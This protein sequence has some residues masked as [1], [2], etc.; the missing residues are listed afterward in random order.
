[1]FEID[2]KGA[3]DAINAQEVELTEFGSII[4][5]YQTLLSLDKSLSVHYVR[6]EANKATTVSF[7][8]LSCLHFPL[9]N[10]C[11]SDHS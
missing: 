6:K 7:D 2:A 8:A 10:I 1:M 3:S 9:L 5:S 11:N 4:L